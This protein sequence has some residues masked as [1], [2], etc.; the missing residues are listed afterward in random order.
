ME[1][2]K[3]H[4][5]GDN[6]EVSTFT[7]TVPA[8]WTDYALI[9]SGNGAKL[10]QFGLYRFVRPESQALWSPTLPQKVWTSADAIFHGDAQ[11]EGGKWQVTHPL[12][13][14][15]TMHYNDIRFWARATSFRHLGVFPEQAAQWDWIRD[16]IQ[17][18]NRP[19]RILNLFGYTGLATLVAASAG[20]SVTHVD[21]SKQSIA[22]AKD[23]QRLSGLEEKPIRWIVDDALKFVEREGRRQARYDGFII[24]PPK[25]G[26]GPKGEVWK[27]YESLPTLLNAC[28]VL[29]SDTPLFAVLTIYAIRL[30][31]LSLQPMIEEMF[32]GH[33]GTTSVG[34]ML[35]AEQSAGRMLST[36]IFARWTSL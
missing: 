1:R 28:R 18:A 35:L 26:R 4:T 12:E 17:R 23:N 19:V 32:A 20:A 3:R 7:F 24:D 14:Q 34:E 2:T 29:L 8:G 36:A 21:A 27:L 5:N 10:E 9:D 13:P 6:L 22:W 33:D 11:E 30:S 16:I 15:W 31:A 25:F